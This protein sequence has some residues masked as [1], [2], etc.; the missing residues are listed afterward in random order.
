MALGPGAMVGT[1]VQ[2]VRAL[3]EGGMGAVW[4][5]RQLSTG[6]EVAVKLIHEGLL[7]DDPTLIDRFEREAAVLSRVNNQ[8]IVK[9]LEHGAMPD[10][11]PYIVMELLSGETIV[12]RLERTEEWMSLEQ[13]GVFL[14]QLASALD[15]IHSQGIVHRDLKGENTMLVGAPDQL[16][17]KLIDFGCAR[18]PDM[19]GHPKLTAPGMLV[20]SA[21]YMSPEQILSARTNPQRGERRRARRHVGRRRAGLHRHHV[22]AALQWRKAE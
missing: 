8:H 7:R 10:G 14:A 5:G 11:T 20:G 18:T 15:P 22:G 4:V 3:D 16:F 12:E 13:V 2:L 17:V 1:D 21:E 9:M 19:T 6:S